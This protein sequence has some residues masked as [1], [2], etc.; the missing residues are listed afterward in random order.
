MDLEG[1]IEARV[2]QATRQRQPRQDHKPP[3]ATDAARRKPAQDRA[4]QRRQQQ[5]HSE[6]AERDARF[7]PVVVQL[8][9]PVGRVGNAVELEDG[10][11]RSRSGAEERIIPGHGPRRVI[12]FL[13][14]LKTFPDLFHARFQRIPSE[15][16]AQ[17]HRQREKKSKDCGGSPSRPAAGSRQVRT[18]RFVTI[19]NTAAKIKMPAATSAPPRLVE[20]T[21][22]AAMIAAQNSRR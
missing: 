22:H 14:V 11:K 21:G 16:P 15:I 19:R 5:R 7:Q 18:N 10:P 20:M 13:A 6:P 12:H 17:R 3:S 2:N 8:F 4:R 1:E 9:R